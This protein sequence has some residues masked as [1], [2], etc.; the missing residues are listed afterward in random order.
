M[1]FKGQHLAL[2]LAGCMLAGAAQ[3]QTPGEQYA[4]VQVAISDVDGFNDNGL[5][6]VGTYGMNLGRTM[7]NFSVEGEITLTIDDPEFSAF[8][9]TFEVSY[10]TLAG[11]GVY[12]LPVSQSFSLYGRAGVLYEDVTV[13]IPTPFGTVEESDSDIGLSFGIGANVAMG[14]T[15]DFTAGI[16]IID[17]DITHF[18][19]GAQFRF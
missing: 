14:R 13:E 15:T 9:E 2:V 12:T 4:K 6:L 7:P 5:A 1:S 16:T 11:Y 8:G 3:A 17:E 10:Y 18:S 19:A